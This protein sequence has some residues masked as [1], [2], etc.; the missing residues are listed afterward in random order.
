MWGWIQLLPQPSMYP[1][2]NEIG[3]GSLMP[4]GFNGENL[5]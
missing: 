4:H 3:E 5:L 1:T 2:P